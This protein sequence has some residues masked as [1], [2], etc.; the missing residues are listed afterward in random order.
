MNLAYNTLIDPIKKDLYDMT[1]KSSHDLGDEF[2]F[3][4]DD[5][6]R[7]EEAY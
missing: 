3:D 4:F 5:L 2:G 1:G 6:F 7:K